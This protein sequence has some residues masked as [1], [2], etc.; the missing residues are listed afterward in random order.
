MYMADIEFFSRSRDWGEQ[1][2]CVYVKLLLY[3][4]MFLYLR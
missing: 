2:A 1:S 3:S 4:L